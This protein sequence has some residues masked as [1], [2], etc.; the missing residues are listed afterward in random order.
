[1]AKKLM[2]AQDGK[3]LKS[4]SS[5]RVKDYEKSGWK[6]DNIG[7]V[8]K[9]YAKD[10]ANTQW[11]SNGKELVGIVKDKTK[12]FATGGIT[13]NKTLYPA[14]AGLMKKGGSMKTKKK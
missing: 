13:K 1:M 2:K 10:T 6:K 12:K 3:T 14:G 8:K 7:A 11:M 5:D 9:G 4:S